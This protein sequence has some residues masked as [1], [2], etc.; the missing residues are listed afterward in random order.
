MW[1]NARLGSPGGRSIEV[2]EKAVAAKGGRE[3]LHQIKSL[4]AYM[5]PAQVTLAGPHTTWLCVFPDRYFEFD[6]RGSGEYPYVASNGVGLAGNPRAIVVNAAVDRVAMDANGTPRVAWR[7][8]RLEQT[9]LTLNQILFLLESAWLQPQPV[10]LKKRILTVE[11][12]GLT[13]RIWLNAA[14]LP[15]RVLELP[16]PHHKSGNLPDFRLEHYREVAGIQLPLR[17]TSTIGMRQWTWDVDYEIDGRINPKFFDRM[18]D[19]S[20]GPEPWRKP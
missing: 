1:A 6:G 4:A 14:N 8:T 2:W 19:L 20:D 5:K 16:P 12:R 18:P 15:E 7:L 10:E 17:L 11:A 9:R 13:Y 3:R